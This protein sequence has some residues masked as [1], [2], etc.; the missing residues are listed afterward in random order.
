MLQKFVNSDFGG[1]FKNGVFMRLFFGRVVTDV[2]DSLY[3]IGSM[4]I[5]LELTG[6]PFYTGVAAALMRIPDIFTVFIGPL[7]D[8]WR[9]RR[10]LLSTQLINGVVVLLVP[11]AA[12]TG[13]LSVWLVLFL[14]PLLKFI[15][16]FVY[17]AQNAALPRLVEEDELTRANSLFSTSLRTVDM[18]ANAIAGALIAIIG[19]VALFV[20]NSVTFA[21]AAIMFVG[22]TVP[23]TNG[24]D[25][26]ETE[27]ATDNGDADEG[28]Y[29]VELRE[30]IDYVRG[31]ALPA[32]LFGMMVNN[33]AAVAVTA[34]LPAFADSIGGPAV[35]GLLVAAIGAGGL[36]GAASAFLVEDFPFGW[37]AA[38]A[39]VS[40]GALIFVAIAVPGVWATALLV[41]IATI[42]TG[43]CNVLF[44]SMV[45]STVDNTLLGRV[46]SL[47]SG[48]LSMMAPAGGL[49]GGALGSAVGSV[50]ALY[51]V[52]ITIG[53]IGI[54]YLLHPQLNDLSPVT[55]INEAQLGLKQPD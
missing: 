28:G 32:V 21:V 36:V 54:Y 55:E 11:L 52:S 14:I 24:K 5:V 20:V 15:N 40:S 47:V 25:D 8:R 38:V 10:I 7:V 39:H 46:T 27:D 33:L 31:S 1:L 37:V 17:P 49:L 34:I 19:A 16:G 12:L 2:G 29:L 51:G 3:F 43:M 26:V 13:H 23:K 48:T 42:P 35:Y 30:G 50:T 18:I 53:L 6:S 22:V 41:F 4:W 45:Q 44:F 9:L